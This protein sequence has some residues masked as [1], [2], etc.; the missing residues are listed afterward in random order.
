MQVAPVLTS[1]APAL[2]AAGLGV[3]QPGLWFLGPLS[4]SYPDL[5]SP[6]VLLIVGTG[7]IS[8]AFTFVVDS[9]AWK[10]RL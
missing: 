1:D 10:Y 5:S 6:R 2:V 9:V 4:V 3:L 8:F 7:W